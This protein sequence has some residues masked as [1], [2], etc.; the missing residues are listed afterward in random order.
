MSHP[1]S[2]AATTAHCPQDKISASL[3]SNTVAATR[4]NN[5]AAVVQALTRM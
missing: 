4:I 1:G 5:M 3:S 2:E